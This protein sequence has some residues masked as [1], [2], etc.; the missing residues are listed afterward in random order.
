MAGSGI[1][2]TAPAW[3]PLLRSLT[4]TEAYAEWQRNQRSAAGGAAGGTA[5]EGSALADLIDGQMQELAVLRGA[6]ASFLAYDVTRGAP[7]FD[8]TGAVLGAAT[9]TIHELLAGARELRLAGLPGGYVI[10]SGDYL[11][12]AY[13]LGQCARRCTAW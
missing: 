10:S 12:F 9:P 6:G 13:G 5:K 7:L 1:A 3:G 2:G 8:P 4:S 11:G